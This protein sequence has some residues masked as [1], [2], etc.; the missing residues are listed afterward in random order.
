MSPETKA[1]LQKHFDALSRGVNQGNNL[2]KIVASAKATELGE[3][4]LILV[5]DY[6]EIGEA[7]QKQMDD[8]TAESLLKMILG[9]NEVNI[10]H[11]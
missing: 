6:P 1:A 5:E 10:K 3:L 7:V 9:V 11:L 2:Q 4:L 8:F